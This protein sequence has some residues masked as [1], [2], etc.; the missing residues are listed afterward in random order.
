[1]SFDL[2][3]FAFRQGTNA[4]AD[5]GAARAVLERF[6]CKH[7]PGTGAYSVSFDDGSDLELY[8]SGLDSD[9]EPFR[10]GMF[11]LRRLTE[12]ITSFI[13][14]FAKAAGCA[15]FPAMEGKIVLLPR[16]DL[17]EHLPADVANE[18]RVMPIDSG[19]ELLAVLDGGYEAWQ[20]YRDRVIERARDDR[21]TM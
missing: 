8:S 4:D 17:A 5:A 7:T 21:Q 19:T 11:A 14:E 12:A 16:D 18:F 1:M 3:L 13:C 9:G 20:A 10:G 15:I 6:A 2:F